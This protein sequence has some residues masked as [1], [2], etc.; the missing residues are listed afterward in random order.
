MMGFSTGQRKKKQTQGWLLL[1]L[2]LVICPLSAAPQPTVLIM[3][4]SL[5]AAYGIEQDA[6]W[7]SLLQNRLGD[8]AEVVNAS[9][10]GETTS[11]GRENA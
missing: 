2:L 8:K 11:G 4:D 9:I 3:G 7:V 5:S 10:S 6:G 1:I